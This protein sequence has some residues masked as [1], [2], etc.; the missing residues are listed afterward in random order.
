[1]RGVSSRTV[2]FVSL[3]VVILSI[4]RAS[5]DF[6]NWYSDMVK[7]FIRLFVISGALTATGAMIWLC[8]WIWSHTLDWITGQLQV[9]NAVRQVL[10]ERYGRKE[11]SK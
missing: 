1:M 5:T 4:V 2:I 3:C 6:D 8:L 9:G 11:R 7:Y 10:W